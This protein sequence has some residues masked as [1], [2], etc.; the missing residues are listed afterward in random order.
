MKM[1]RILLMLIAVLLTASSTMAQEKGSIRLGAGLVYGTKSGVDGAGTEKGGYG[2]TVGG[3]YFFTNKLSAAPSFS[4]FIKSD[5]EGGSVAFNTIDIDGRYYLGKSNF[6]FYG[7]VGLSIASARVKS[8]SIDEQG[9]SN[10]DE[11]DSDIGANIGAGVVYPLS[12]RFS[13]NGQVKVNTPMQQAA[14]QA[15]VSFTIK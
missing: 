14:L 6:N 4:Y 3:E 15:G 7:L 5:I 2:F 13:L 8:S 10:Y 11:S 12:N 1:K 9:T